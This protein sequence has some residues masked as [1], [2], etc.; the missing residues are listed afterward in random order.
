MTD[1]PDSGGPA[2][3][4]PADWRRQV[5]LQIRLLPPSSPFSPKGDLTYSPSLGP[6]TYPHTGLIFPRSG[7]RLVKH[8]I[9]CLNAGQLELSFPTIHTAP[10]AL[11]YFLSLPRIHTAP[12]S[13]PHLCGFGQALHFSEH[14]APLPL[15]GGENAY[16]MDLS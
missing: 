7:W 10:A 4:S 1:W 12:P 14:H 13:Y 11:S 15:N 8:V 9:Y 2:P 3:K 6:H 16:F 5:F